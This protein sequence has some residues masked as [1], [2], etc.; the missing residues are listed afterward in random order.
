MM[1]FKQYQIGKN[2]IVTNMHYP[3]AIHLQECYK[4]LNIK[5][6]ELPIAEELSLTELSLPIFYG[7]TEDQISHVI[8]TVNKFN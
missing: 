2:N 7:M 8:E 3:T 6:G 4:D 5:K 1:K